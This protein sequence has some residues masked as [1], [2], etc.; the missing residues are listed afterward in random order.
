MPERNPLVLIDGQVQEL[1]LGDT[2]SGS[3]SSSGFSGA[4]L[5]LSAAII[6]P[7]GNNTIISFDSVAFDVGT[8]WSIGN[9]SRLTVPTGVTKIVVTTGT[10]ADTL[11]ASNQ[12]YVVRLKKN[13]ITIITN[14]LDNQF[15]GPAPLTT[16]VIDVVATDYFEVEYWSTHNWELSETQTFFNVFAVNSGVDG[17]TVLNGTVDPSS[18]GVDG[19]FYIN[20][21]SNTIFGPKT[22]GIW[23]IGVSLIGPAG[24]TG[25][26]GIGLPTGGTTAQVLKKVD[27]TDF[28]TH[29]V[30]ENVT[31]I[32]VQEQITTT[33][34][35][36]TNADFIGSKFKKVTQACTITIEPGATNKHPVSFIPTTTGM[37][38]F[39]AGT[40]VTIIS[41]DNLVS[42]RVRGSP[43]TLVQDSDV[44]ETYFLMGDL[45]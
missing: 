27:A 21:T 39:V 25:M 26:T 8:W 35:S 45:A 12:D 11:Q 16:G 22:N 10:I 14:V 42:T 13:G 44:P 2:T 31:S 32:M 3:G 36:T 17:S 34:Y 19:D 40:G 5:T 28:N 29:W 41:P 43:V 30:D 38:T 4:S 33:T 24:P 1:P 37:I 9:P 7:A 6:I 20:T 23:P 18:E 15:W